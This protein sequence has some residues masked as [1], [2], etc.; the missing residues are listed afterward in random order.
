MN[1]FEI[2]QHSNFWIQFFKD[3]QILVPSVV[4]DVSV[5]PSG[6]ALLSDIP[7]VVT[8]IP[9]NSTSPK[10]I[11]NCLHQTD[12]HFISDVVKSPGRVRMISVLPS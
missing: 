6:I 10:L 4:T 9:G 2:I 3:T 11:S 5:V 8:L 7:S 1:K 12:N